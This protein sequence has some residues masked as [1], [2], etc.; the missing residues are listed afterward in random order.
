LDR[1]CGENEKSKTVFAATD[2]HDSENVR[3][4]AGNECDPKKINPFSAWDDRGA[5]GRGDVTCCNNDNDEREDRTESGRDCRTTPPR[6]KSCRLITA[7][8]MTRI[9]CRR[10]VRHRLP[11][12]GSE[13]RLSLWPEMV[14]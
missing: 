6:E 14:D 4:E 13:D 3:R 11:E 5:V 1:C 12:Y 10:R 9:E 8:R 7:R 2:E